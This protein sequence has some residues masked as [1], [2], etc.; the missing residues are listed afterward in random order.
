MRVEVEK[1]F[2]GVASLETF[3]SSSENEVLKFLVNIEHLKMQWAFNELNLGEY[4]VSK[5]IKNSK[6]VYPSCL[7]GSSIKDKSVND[8]LSIL[9]SN[10]ILKIRIYEI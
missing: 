7:G 6:S 5:I 10:Y 3:E 9:L 1:I 4:K 2:Y 8:K